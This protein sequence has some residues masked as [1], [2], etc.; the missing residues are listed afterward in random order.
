MVAVSLVPI[1]TYQVPIT[2]LEAVY[3]S[4]EHTRFLELDT[5]KFLPF[6]LWCPAL[7]SEKVRRQ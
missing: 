4:H 1:A 2:K 3:G 6:L 5:T 7:L